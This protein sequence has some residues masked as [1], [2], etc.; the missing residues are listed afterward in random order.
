MHVFNKHELMIFTVAGNSVEESTSAR[1][2]KSRGVAWQKL[3]SGH[4]ILVSFTNYMSEPSCYVQSQILLC[5]LCMENTR[6]CP[7]TRTKSIQRRKKKLSHK[8]NHV[9]LVIVCVCR[10]ELTEL[11]SKDGDV[12]NSGFVSPLAK[13]FLLSF[14]IFWNFFRQKVENLC[15]TVAGCLKE[16]AFSK[17]VEF[18]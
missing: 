16:Y 11:A 12:K 14:I 1:W 15:L 6:M 5:V 4:P 17:L 13:L 18:V 9:R 7:Q 3:K 10:W 2:F 8:Y